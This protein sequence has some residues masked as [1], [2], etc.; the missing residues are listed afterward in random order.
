MPRPSM[1]AFSFVPNVLR[2]YVSTGCGVCLLWV[3][4]EEENGMGII[5]DLLCLLVDIAV[6]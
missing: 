4:V 3:V 6:L 1:S 2:R 5:D